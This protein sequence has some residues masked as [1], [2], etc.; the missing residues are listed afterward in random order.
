V[1]IAVLWTGLSGYLNACLRELASRP[2]VELFVA[3]SEI[4]NEAPY[5]PGIFSWIKHEVVWQNSGD[6]ERLHSE[7]TAFDPEVVVVAGWHVPL[8]RRI[9]KPLKGRCLRL[10]TMDNRWSGT[11]RQWLGSLTATTYVLPYADA[12]WVPGHHQANFARKMGFPLRNILHGSLSCE[13]PK[14]A[15]I[16][17]ERVHA[18]EPVPHAFIF[19]GRL[20]EAKG[21]D[22][23]AEGYRRYRASVADPWP[24]IICGTGPLRSLLDNQPGIL[25]KGFVQ[26]EDLPKQLAFAGCLLLPSDFEPW[27][28]V[29]NEA[30][31]AG[32]IIVATDKV[33]AVPHLV[34]NY[35]NGFI[36]NVSDPAALAEVMKTVSCMTPERI[37]RMARASYDLSRQYTP[38]RWTNALIDFATDRR[39]GEQ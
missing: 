30:T 35:Y 28:L 31:A 15:A 39:V 12:A 36:V 29:V 32:L 27:A 4:K 13:Q 14:F 10:M 11:A 6:Y 18:G 24:L 34:Q 20:I 37:E 1:R 5:D 25:L 9:M 16:Y 21:I 22:T 26:P 7:L 38:K 23:L 3:H 33:G 8:Y 19:V 17:E 2:G